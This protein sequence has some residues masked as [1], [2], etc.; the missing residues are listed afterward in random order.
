M[1]PAGRGG[2]REGEKVVRSLVS[3]WFRPTVSGS[4]SSSDGEDGAAL[5]PCHV[6]AYWTNTDTSRE[7]SND[8]GLA[9]FVPSFSSCRGGWTVL[10]L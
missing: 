10:Q 9:A 5:R 4:S 6:L 1:Q 3:R 2:K 7:D 8:C